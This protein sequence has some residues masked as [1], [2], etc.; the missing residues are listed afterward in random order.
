MYA[1]RSYYASL[2]VP[3]SSLTA[4]DNV[5]VTGYLVNTSA[6]KPL[7]SVAGWSATAPTS[8][9][10]PAAGTVTFYAWAKDAAGNVSA[11]RSAAVVI[12]I[13]VADTTAPTV[14][15]F[16]LPATSTSLTVPRITSYNV[17]YTKLLRSMM[18]SPNTDWR[19]PA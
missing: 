17:C 12:T 10:A 4:T 18:T 11:A 13:T 8:V 6:T 14:S 19:S 7:A 16:T 15:A 5:G 9:T 2:S 1:I 3:V